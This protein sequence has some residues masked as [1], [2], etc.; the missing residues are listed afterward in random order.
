[1]RRH[2]L[3]V[4]LVGCVHQATWQ[5]R[6]TPRYQ[7]HTVGDVTVATMVRRGCRRDPCRV[8]MLIPGGAQNVHL[9]EMGL[10]PFAHELAGLGWIV[11]SPAVPIGGPPFHREPE[12]LLPVVTD[13]I[14]RHEVDEVHLIGTSNGG[15]AS[16]AFA[17]RHPELVAST[18]VMPGLLPSAD[19]TGVASIDHPVRWVVGSRDRWAEAVRVDHAALTAAGVDST[20][21]VVDG[22]GHVLFDDVSAPQISRWLDPSLGSDRVELSSPILD[23]HWS[24]E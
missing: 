20:L 11:V 7:R 18:L 22:A 5:V 15:L 12:R 4:L 9:M 3:G 10:R 16:L 8:V 23:N 21:H 2:W 17:I 24:I 6:A 1:M 19:P 13:T 14:R